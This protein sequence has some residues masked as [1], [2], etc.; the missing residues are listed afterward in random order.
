MNAFDYFVYILFPVVVIVGGVGGNLIGLAVLSSKNMTKL[1][2]RNVYRYM[3]VFDT[4][5][6]S[7][8]VISYMQYGYNYDPTISSVGFCKVFNY[9]N[10]SLSLMSPMLIVYVSLER[11]LS[12]KYSKRFQFFKSNKFQV[13]YLFVVVIFNAFYYLGIAFYF[14]IVPVDTASANLTNQSGETTIQCTFATNDS[15]VMYSW[16]DLVNRAIVP[17]ILMTMGTILLSHSIFQSRTRVAGNQSIT[18]NKNFKKDMKFTVTS[19]FLNLVYVLLNLPI[20]ITIFFPNYQTSS[21]Y[22][23]SFFLFYLSY[24]VNFYIILTF[25]S[26]I[27]NEFLS[28]FGCLVNTRNQVTNQTATYTLNGRQR[29]NTVSAVHCHA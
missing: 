11:Y 16:M 18:E 28:F 14:D 10:Y 6:I 26:M 1:S 27:R 29:V 24:G 25:N 17:T 4:L 13:T 21:V 5:F 12:I 19:I 3:L 15:L 20:S 22:V 23:F 8:S 7:Q 2:I 9:F